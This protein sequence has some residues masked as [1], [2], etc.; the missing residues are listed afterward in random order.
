MSFRRKRKDNALCAMGAACPCDACAFENDNY[1]CSECEGVLDP[2]GDSEL[3]AECDEALYL[4]S[5][6]GLQELRDE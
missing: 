4:E 6:Q 1:F 3:C 2:N 5:I